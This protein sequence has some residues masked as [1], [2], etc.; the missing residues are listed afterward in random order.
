[1]SMVAGCQSST[2]LL[3]PFYGIVRLDDAVS[4]KPFAAFLMLC[5]PILDLLPNPPL[6]EGDCVRSCRSMTTVKYIVDRHYGVFSHLPA[7]GRRFSGAV[8]RT[9][10]RE[11][12]SIM[13]E[14]SEGENSW[15]S[16]I[17]TSKPMCAGSDPRICI[18]GVGER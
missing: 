8:Q 16:L 6:L 9:A 4:H 15:N 1:M 7:R 13:S 12:D 5:L 10:L 18:S 17:K 11:L 14:A 3:A 2:S